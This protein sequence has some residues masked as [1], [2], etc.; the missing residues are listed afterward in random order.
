MTNEKLYKILKSFDKLDSLDLKKE[1]NESNKENLIEKCYLLTMISIKFDLT[2]NFNI[3]LEKCLSLMDTALDIEEQEKL[4]FTIISLYFKLGLT[5]NLLEH[6]T[7]FRELN[8]SNP[9][10]LYNIAQF[11]YLVYLENGFYKN[12]FHEIKRLKFNGYKIK[13]VP[14]ELIKYIVAYNSIYVY[15]YQRDFKRVE[16]IYQYIEDIYNNSLH[17]RDYIEYSFNG[18]TLIKNYVISFNSKYF[19]EYIEHLES[20][21]IFSSSI[22]ELASVNEIMLNCMYKEGMYKDCIRACKALLKS[23]FSG[24]KKLVYK[25][26]LKCFIALD[27]KESDEYHYFLDQYLKRL[28]FSCEKYESLS[29][30]YIKDSINLDKLSNDYKELKKKYIED[31]LTGCLSRHAFEL[32]RKDFYMNNPNGSLAF[33]DINNLKQVNDLYGHQCGDEFIKEFS[34]N[35]SSKLDEESDTLFRYG[36]DEFIILSKS[37]K[38]ELSERLDNCQTFFREQVL[39][40]TGETKLKIMFSYGVAAIDISMEETINIADALMYK[41]KRRMQ[42]K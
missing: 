19:K 4:Q 33:I 40:H 10:Y 20:A 28:E 25:I 42:I 16:D 24:D 22:K 27:L 41:Q 11:M 7:R 37:P 23:Y 8:C 30:F 3:I 5:P 26:I 17:I 29:K 36:G 31:K 39:L 14:D 12:A 6:V 18:I 32:Y 21:P 2:D 38:K 1:L 9:Y 13:N 35:F 15:T 34:T